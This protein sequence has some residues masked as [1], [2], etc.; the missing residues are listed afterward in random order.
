MDK[1]TPDFTLNVMHEILGIPEVVDDPKAMTITEMAKAYGLNKATIR[2][3]VEEKLGEGKLEK[4]FVKR[5]NSLGH[6]HTR[7]AYR[8]VRAD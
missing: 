7:E 5:P 1:P 4:V 2:G 6:L 8:P 3:M